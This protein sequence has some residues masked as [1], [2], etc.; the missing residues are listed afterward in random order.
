MQ[1]L[2]V[3]ISAH[4]FGH[5]AQTTAILNALETKHLRLTIRSMAPEAILRARIRHPFTLI[6][7]KQDEGMVMHNAMRVDAARTYQWYAAF[8]STY[9]QR[10]KQAAY[11]LEQLQPDLLFA[12]VPYLSLAA[13]GQI[14]LPAI[15][16]CSL[17]WADLF[18]FYCQSF[19]EAKTIYQ[20]IHS[21]YRQ[22]EVF[23]RSTPAMPMSAFSHTQAIAPIA[24]YGQAQHLA[25]LTSLPTNPSTKFVLNAL[26]GGMGIDYPL[27]NWPRLPNVYWIFPDEALNL[28]RE[29]FVPLSHFGL[30][31]ADLVA[32]CD[33]IIAKTGYGIQ[34][35]AVIHQKPLLCVDREEWPEQPW[36]LSWHQ[37]QG[38]VELVTWQQIASGQF[39]AQVEQLLA[40]PW[41]KPKIKPDG[42]NQ[43]ADIIHTRLA[44]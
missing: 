10:V 35:E 31:Y 38:V 42:A 6:P 3:D 13:A 33:L 8:H 36:L 21:A 37:Q 2:L 29:D 14:Q 40:T 25:Q 19:P 44:R 24:L 32:S 1:H 7:Y 9:A 34:T 18:Q 28:S 30:P 17:N 26:G 27:A 12:N 43:A 20:Q 15:A 11:D 39:A 5:V 23:L 16:L 22:A 41:S 4:G